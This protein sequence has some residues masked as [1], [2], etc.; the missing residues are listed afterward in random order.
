MVEL[1]TV[2][3]AGDPLELRRNGR[4]P[5]AVIFLNAHLRVVGVHRSDLRA[6]NFPVVTKSV[7]L[8][9]LRSLKMPDFPPREALGSIDQV[10]F[11][12]LKSGKSVNID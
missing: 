11:R 1:S 7:T 5:A 8:E 6:K 2:G 10:L 12:V 3:I 4:A 9:R